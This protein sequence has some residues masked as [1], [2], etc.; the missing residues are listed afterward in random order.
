MTFLLNFCALSSAHPYKVITSGK[1][2]QNSSTNLFLNFSSLS[3]MNKLKVKFFISTPFDNKKFTTKHRGIV[4]FSKL[5]ITTRGR[6]DIC[7][8]LHPIWLTRKS[9]IHSI[10]SSEV[11]MIKSYCLTAERIS[12]SDQAHFLNK[13]HFRSRV[14]LLNPEN[15]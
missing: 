9:I 6:Y 8:I 5:C 1:F 2:T 10:F 12:S 7:D 11:V 3:P 14:D 4:Q 13:S 15:R